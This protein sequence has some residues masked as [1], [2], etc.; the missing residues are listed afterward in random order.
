MGFKTKSNAKNT[1]YNSSEAY[2]IKGVIFESL[3]SYEDLKNIDDNAQ[4]LVD[5]I[6]AGSLVMKEFFGRFDKT[7]VK[8]THADAAE[9][10]EF[11]FPNISR[12]ICLSDPDYFKTELDFADNFYSL[13]DIEY[14]S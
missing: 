1:S 12:L 11:L 5:S 2:K 9:Y 8:E 6:K 13:L 14:F 10:L 4:Q 7:K 3:N